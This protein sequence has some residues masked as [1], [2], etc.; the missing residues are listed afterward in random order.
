M[1][2][3]RQHAGKTT[4]SLALMSGLRKRF[5]EDGV[6]FMKPIGQS[7][8]MEGP[9]M[10]DK[11]AHLFQKY[12]G[13]RSE[14][15]DISPVVFP[16][17]YTEMFIDGKVDPKNQEDRIVSSFQHLSS[18]HR[19]VL[20]EGSGHVGVG[21][22][23]EINNAKV[24]RLL[25]IPV[26]LIVNSGLGSAFDDLSLNVALCKQEG[27]AVH[28]VIM[29]RM[30][31]AK[32]AKIRS[33]MERALRRWDVPLLSVIPDLAHLDKPTFAYFEK[34][35]RTTMLS[36]RDHA[37]QY[38]TN[39]LLVSCDAGRFLELVDSQ[40]YGD[41]T[42]FLIHSTRIDLIL[43][44]L[45]WAHHYPKIH[46]KPFT[47]GLLL[48]GE[49]TLNSFV[50]R[51]VKDSGLPV[52]HAPYPSYE[53]IERIKQDTYKHDIKHPQKIKDAIEHYEKH[54]DFDALLRS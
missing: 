34:V 21:S 30:Q 19:F 48:T 7:Y 37:E 1:A 47:G 23:C 36:G 51:A 35:F 3:T 40:Q 20:V 50:L 14:W 27:V 15:R 2:G 53:T 10:I 52:L 28:G 44:Y 22:I 32:S 8:V 41:R 9:L 13:L 39:S 17:G 31:A 33:Y 46:G 6:A 12:F 54:I 25:G 49:C 26:V 16:K 11:D 45:E 29:N 18:T 38:Y 5:G 4:T 43:S 42:L 24:A